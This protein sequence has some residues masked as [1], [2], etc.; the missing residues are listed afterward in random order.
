MKWSEVKD[1]CRSQGHQPWT[2]R[3]KTCVYPLLLEIKLSYL[4]Q[5]FRLK[6]LQSELKCFCN[7]NDFYLN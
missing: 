7:L 3:L 2:L 1:Y 6:G 5:C 4:K